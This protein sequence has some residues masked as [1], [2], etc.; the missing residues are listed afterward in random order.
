MYHYFYHPYM[1]KKIKVDVVIPVYNEEKELEENI[2]KLH[3]FLTQKLSKYSWQ[4]VIA[5]NASTDKSLNIAQKLQKSL[6]SVK[7]IHLNQKGRGR[8]VKLAWQKSSADIHS[9]MDVDLSTDLR[10]F[11]SLVDTLLHGQDIAIGSRLMTKSKVAQRPIKR[12]VLSRIYNILIRLFFQIRFSDAQCGFKSVNKRVVR[13]LLPLI[14]DNGWFFDSEL[15]IIGEK[16]GYKI[17]EIPVIW[18]DNPGSTVRVLKTI[19]GDLSGLW[20]LFITKPWNNIK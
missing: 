18:I 2:K 15:L 5:D 20:R 19:Y 14:K 17:A 6:K 16:M 9:Y 3:H 1:P 4:I 12:E 8:A 7:V 13:K 10:S 11:P